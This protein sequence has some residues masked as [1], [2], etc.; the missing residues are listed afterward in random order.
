[1]FISAGILFALSFAG[2]LQNRNN[3]ESSENI[4]HLQVLNKKV[5]AT[6]IYIDKL[7]PENQSVVFGKDAVLV[8]FS[9]K[10]DSPRLRLPKHTLDILWLDSSYIVLFGEKRTGNE[11]DNILTPSEDT[12]FAL[13]T[14]SGELPGEAFKKGFN[15]LVSEK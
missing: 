9:K 2:Y 15:V 10:K 11:K 1:M 7:N 13:I 6:T 4:L 8:V 14:N 12:A 3:S 5:D